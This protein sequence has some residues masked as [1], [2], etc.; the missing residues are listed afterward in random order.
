MNPAELNLN[1]IDQISPVVIVAVMLIVMVLYVA[2]RKVY[3]TP[4]LRVLEDRERLFEVA[5]AKNAEAT[6]CVAAAGQSSEQ[7]VAEAV[8]EAEVMRAEARERADEY[9]RT[10]VGEVASAAALRLET[11]RAQ[12]ATSRAVE[13]DRLRREADECVHVAC[14]Q[15]LGGVDDE[16]VEAT[17]ERL[18]TRQAN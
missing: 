11:G 12:I 3:V 9:R 8:A 13:L 7:A 6:Q 17:V 1:P 15:L 16:L 14:E 4:Y 10:R 18:I 2:L 5:D